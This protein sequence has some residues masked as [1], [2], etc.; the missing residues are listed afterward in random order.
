MFA[1][2]KAGHNPALPVR[3]EVWHGDEPG[4]RAAWDV[5]SV[6][7]AYHQIAKLEYKSGQQFTVEDTS[8]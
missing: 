3:L 6:K 5:P 1:L 8:R 7:M 2:I 4:K